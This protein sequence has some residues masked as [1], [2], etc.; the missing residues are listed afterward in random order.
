MFQTPPGGAPPRAWCH[1][2]RGP[3]S[4]VE[5]AYGRNIDRSNT[6]WTLGHPSIAGTASDCWDARFQHQ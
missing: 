6:V 2:D 3:P 4:S 1:G 5:E